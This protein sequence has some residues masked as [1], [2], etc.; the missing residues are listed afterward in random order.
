MVSVPELLSSSPWISNIGFLILFAD[1]KGLISTYVLVASQSVL[2]SFYANKL[3]KSLHSKS[4]NKTS[5]KWK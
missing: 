5:R 1:I 4:E 3:N 2:S